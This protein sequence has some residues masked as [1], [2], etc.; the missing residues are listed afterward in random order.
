MNTLKSYYARFLAVFPKL[1]LFRQS[2]KDL[3]IAIA[4]S[5][6]LIAGVFVVY[7]LLDPA[8]PRHFAISTGDIHSNYYSLGLAYRDF[9]RKEG[10]EME[11]LPSKGAWN[12]LR[13]LEDEDSRVLVGFVQDGLGSRTKQP[14]VSS[15]G[16][17]FFEPVWVFYRGPHTLSRL[18]QMEGMRI[19]AGEKGGEAFTM[20]KRLFRDSGVEESKI[21]LVE[22]TMDEQVRMLLEGNVDAALFVSSTS[23]PKIQQLLREEGLHLLSLDQAEAIS[24]RMPYLHH[25]VLPHG[26]IDLKKNI[27]SRDTD[28]VAATATLVVRN[29]IHPAL[30]YLLMRAIS[31]VHR[32]PGLFEKKGEFPVDNDYVFPAH[33]GAKDYLKSGSPF[34]FRHLPFWLATM[35]ERI[36]LLVIPVAALVIPVIRFIPQFLRWRIRTRIY[37]LY[38]ELKNIEKQ[39]TEEMTRTSSGEVLKKLDVVEEKINS[40]RFPLEVSDTVYHLREHVHFVRSRVRS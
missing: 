16:S 10:I 22:G 11:V 4:P 13:R 15:L 23:N 18:N 12:N 20:A 39:T 17:L 7:H 14:N 21:K 26:A 29:D 8:P 30:V 38:G 37:R 5:L 9:I 6:L 40:G 25:L 28:L 31:K 36:L 35:I 19:A 2:P 3:L 33:P 24:R 34:W 32:D 27:P 1:D